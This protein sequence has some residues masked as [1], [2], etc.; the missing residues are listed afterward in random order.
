MCLEAKCPVPTCS[1]LGGTALSSSV[2]QLPVLCGEGVIS[3]SSCKILGEM[4]IGN[5][6]HLFLF[7]ATVT[8]VMAILTSRM[9]I[10]VAHL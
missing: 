3:H 10:L 5:K 1:A 9:G 2:S 6:S 8:K 7:Q 4:N